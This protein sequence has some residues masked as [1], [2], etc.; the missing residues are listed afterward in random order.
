MKKI[1][2]WLKNIFISIDQLGNAIA[3]GNPDVTISS[4]VGYFSNCKE[5]SHNFYYYWNTLEIIIDTAF[6]PLEGKHHCRNAYEETK[7]HEH[8]NDLARGLLGVFVVI[9]CIFISIVTWGL[10]LL[11]YRPIVT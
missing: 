10:Y 3:G 8:G 2:T 1:A 5:A 6:Y 4:R 9:G 11:G 7:M